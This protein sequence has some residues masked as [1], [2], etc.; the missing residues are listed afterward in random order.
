MPQTLSPRE[1]AGLQ[2]AAMARLRRRGEF[3]LVPSHGQGRGGS[4]HK[5]RPHPTTPHCSCPDHTLH[6]GKCKHI[7]AVEYARQRENAVANDPHDEAEIP[8]APPPRKTYP[9]AWKA[10]NAAQTQEKA[11]FQHLLKELVRDVGLETSEASNGRPRFPLEDALFCA[12]FKVYATFSARRFMSDLRD[13]HGKGYISSVPHFNTILNYLGAEA[14]TSILMDLV[15]RSSK[16]L[17]G[18]ETDFAVDSTGFS[19]SRFDRWFD[20]RQKKLRQ[21]HSWVKAHAVCGVKTNVVTAVVIGEKNAPDGRQL[22][23]LLAKTAEH[24]TMREVSADKAYS[25]FANLD[26]VDRY[27]ATPFIAFR[28]H[29][30]GRGPKVWEK[31][32][33]MFQLEREAFFAHYHKRSNIEACFS[34][35]KRKFGDSVRSRLQVSMKNEV[36]CKIICHN[37]CVL[38]QE[39]HELGIEL[40]YE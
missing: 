7:Y 38:I 24:F 8:V 29:V 39:A 35:I 14:T 40:K 25:S 12:C 22:P 23:Q 16:P 36:L 20:H 33:L 34:M 9:Q 3:W 15:A 5:V 28:R 26:H 30:S 4:P 27:G 31:M 19:S 21:E 11:I 6:G 1:I 18:I 32:F 2:I 13:A 37:I 10:Y 17:S